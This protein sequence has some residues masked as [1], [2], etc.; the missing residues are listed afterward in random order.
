MKKKLSKNECK[1][2]IKEWKQ[3]LLYS[4]LNEKEQNKR[5]R[6]FARKGIKPND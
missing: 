2:L 3:H 1:K 5:A 4:R 6:E